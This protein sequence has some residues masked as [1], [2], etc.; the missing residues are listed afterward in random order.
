M[1]F[2]DLNE[3]DQYK[4]CLVVY[5]DMVSSEMNNNDLGNDHFILFF[6]FVYIYIY[7]HYNDILKYLK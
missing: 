3:I 4:L 6:N 2:Y 5:V 7:K 1:T